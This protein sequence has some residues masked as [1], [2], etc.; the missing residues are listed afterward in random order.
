MQ[1]EELTKLEYE[2]KSKLLQK[3]ED[4]GDCVKSEKTRF[5]VENLEADMLRLQQSI[6]CICSSMVKLIDD[7]MYP[8]LC[9]LISG[10]G[11][12]DISFLEKKND[13]MS[14]L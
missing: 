9:R 8:Q 5:I 1:E 2:R 7:E 4:E 6:S 11:D 3:Q 13:M 14:A 12:H 10:Y